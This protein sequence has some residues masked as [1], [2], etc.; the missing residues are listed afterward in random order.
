MEGFPRHGGMINLKLDAERIRLEVNPDNATRAGLKIRS[1][2][3]RLADVVR[4]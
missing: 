4:D 2:L 1:E 3:L